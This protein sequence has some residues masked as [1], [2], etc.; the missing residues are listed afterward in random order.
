MISYG[1]FNHFMYGIFCFGHSKRY[2]GCWACNLVLHLPVI[3]CHSYLVHTIRL[4]LSERVLRFDNLV[5]AS[6]AAT[7]PA[8]EMTELLR[9]CCCLAPATFTLFRCSATC[10]FVM[11]KW[12]A[13]SLWLPTTRAL[14]KQSSFLAP[15]VTMP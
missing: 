3:M 1:A 10:K 2:K 8:N 14:G 11:V 15:Y 12:S 7:A 13:W 4:H 6:V 9:Y 5:H